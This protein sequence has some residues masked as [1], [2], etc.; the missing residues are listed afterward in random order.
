MIPVHML[1]QH[2]ELLKLL[3]PGLNLTEIWCISMIKK[4]TVEKKEWSPQVGYQGKAV[5]QGAVGKALS[6]GAQGVW[7]IALT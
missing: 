1:L 6:A 7:D 4:P 5:P 2:T 3:E